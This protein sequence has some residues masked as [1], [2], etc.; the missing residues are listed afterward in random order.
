MSST[1]VY[2]RYVAKP[3]H[4][5]FLIDGNIL[6]LHNGPSKN[7]RNQIKVN[8]HLRITFEPQIAGFRP[9]THIYTE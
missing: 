1:V 3:Q 2:Y 4:D 6:K 5:S 7:L 9:L 8:D